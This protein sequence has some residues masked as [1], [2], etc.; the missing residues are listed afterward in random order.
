MKTVNGDKVV[1]DSHS[2]VILTEYLRI[3]DRL[4]MAVHSD[5]EGWAERKVQNGSTGTVVGFRRYSVFQSRIG[6]YKTEPGKYEANGAAIV[7]WDSGVF[8]T[9]SMQDV[10]FYPGLGTEDRSKDKAYMDAFRVYTRIGDLPDLPFWE[11]DYVTI[12]PGRSSAW[13]DNTRLIVSRINYEYFGETCN[14][15]VTPM[16]MYQVE[17]TSMDRGRV[18]LRESDLLFAERGNVWWWYHDR[19][20]MKFSSLEEEVRF[21]RS[22]GGS[23]DVICPQ[24]G[25]YSWPAEAVLKGARSG[26]IDAL[27]TSEGFFNSGRHVQACKMHEADL[28]ARANAALLEGFKA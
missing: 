21:H 23:T 6:V 24:T 13:E 1:D 2:R 8:D 19:Q 15:G 18:S 28:S 26:I 10:V 25:D 22:I 4:M 7:R 12:V 16:P 3:G 9:P 14:D 27:R 20:R 17:P 5:D 11:G